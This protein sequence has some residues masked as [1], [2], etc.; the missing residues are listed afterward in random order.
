MENSLKVE[1]HLKNRQKS[2]WVTKGW[3]FFHGDVWPDDMASKRTP[4]G[5]FSSSLNIVI[6]SRKLMKF[7]F[8]EIWSFSWF[9]PIFYVFWPIFTYLLNFTNYVGK[10]RFLILHQLYQ[11]STVEEKF[12][13]SLDA[14]GNAFVKLLFFPVFSQHLLTN[15]DFI[16]ALDGNS[17]QMKIWQ[18]HVFSQSEISEIRI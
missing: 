2:V 17:L 7:D 18:F 6:I 1:N 8:F 4:M 12:G 13:R 16:H 3:G 9:W 14:V 11:F 10:C 15:V 5:V